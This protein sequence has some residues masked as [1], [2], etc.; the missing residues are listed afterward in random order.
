MFR[1]NWVFIDRPADRFDAAETFWARVTGSAP[2]ERRG[3]RGEFVTL[4]PAQGDPCLRMQAVGDSGGAHLDLD[5]ED[6]AAAREH[7]RS[8][9]ASLVTDYGDYALMRSPAGMAFCLTTEDGARIPPPTPSPGPGLSRL[10]QICLDIGP[11]AFDA[12][13]RFWSALTGWDLLSTTESEFTRL[14]V[15]D[16]FP[17]RILLQRLDEDGAPAAHLDLSCSDVANVAVW[18]ESL[19]AQRVGEFPYWTVMRDPAAGVYCLTAR[20]PHTGKVML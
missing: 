1:W 4:Y 6:L 18:H 10:D 17:V 7:A 13:A 8:L 2:S 9:G 19:G 14:A 15:P 20:D 11:G 5:V 3:D 12:E 16:R